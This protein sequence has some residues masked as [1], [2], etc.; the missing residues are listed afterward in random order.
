MFDRE[1]KVLNSTEWLLRTDFRFFSCFVVVFCSCTKSFIWRRD[2]VVKFL[3]NNIQ[4]HQFSFFYIRVSAAYGQQRR[5]DW[6]SV[7]PGLGV[8]IR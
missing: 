4:H 3:K 7:C 5:T 8:K 1:K 2:V 6:W